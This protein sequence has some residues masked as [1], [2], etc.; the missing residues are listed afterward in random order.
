MLAALVHFLAERLQAMLKLG[1]AYRAA[2]SDHPPC[3]S[4]TKLFRIQLS[5]LHV[6]EED[7]VKSW[8]N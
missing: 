5:D 6:P 7:S 4:K 3:K 2:S 8:C 1:A